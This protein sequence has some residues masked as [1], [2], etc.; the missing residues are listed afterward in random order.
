MALDIFDAIDNGLKEK[1]QHLSSEGLGWA[2]GI[3]F[4]C[5]TIPSMLA[6]IWGFTDHLPS[7]DVVLFVWAGLF[8]LFL[9][10]VIRKDLL[11]VVTIGTGFIIQAGLLAMVVYK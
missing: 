7:L 9:R 1:L 4:H 6:L 10:A 11:N 5:A 2:A 3:L 8:L